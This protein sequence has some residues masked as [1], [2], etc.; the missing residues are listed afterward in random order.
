MLLSTLSTKFLKNKLSIDPETNS[1]TE[2]K[3]NFKFTRI[4]QQEASSSIIMKRNK[5]LSIRNCSRFFVCNKE[6][7][8]KINDH[9]DRLRRFIAK[10]NTKF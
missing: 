3:D 9:I 5:D 1:G 10:M 6:E 4:E 8:I 2:V 7:E